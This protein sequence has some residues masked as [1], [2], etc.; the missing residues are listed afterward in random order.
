MTTAA[1]AFLARAARH[2]GRPAY[3]AL[4][5]GGAPHDAVLTWG[6]WAADARRFAAALVA[7]GLKPG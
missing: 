4:A 2:P 7:D 5:A 6:A 3:R 1:R